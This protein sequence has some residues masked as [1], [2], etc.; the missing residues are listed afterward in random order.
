V[1]ITAP[2]MIADHLIKRV[3]GENRARQRNTRELKSSRA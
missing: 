2:P 3:L 1:I